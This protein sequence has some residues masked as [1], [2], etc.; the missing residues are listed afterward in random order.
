MPCQYNQPIRK[1]RG[2]SVNDEKKKYN[3]LKL[4]KLISKIFNGSDSV[5][6]ED[7]AG[8]ILEDLHN[9]SL[10]RGEEHD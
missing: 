2:L 9:L 3:S 10:I 1:K 6:V 8:N 4:N 7:V 5:I